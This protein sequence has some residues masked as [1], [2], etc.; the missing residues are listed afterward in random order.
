MKRRKKRV[1]EKGNLKISI[2][3]R[4]HR[5]DRLP[6][7]MDVAA[8]IVMEFMGLVSLTVASL[9]FRQH[10]KIRGKQ[11][12]FLD[13][14]NSQT[15]SERGTGKCFSS[16]WVMDNISHK[17]RKL[18]HATP[19]LM[20]SISLAVGVFAICVGTY[21][22]VNIISFGYALFVALIGAA[23]LLGTDAFEAYSYTNAIR[24]VALEQLDK[25]DQSYIELARDAMEKAFLRFSSMGVAFALLGPFIPQIFNV[26]VN[27]FMVYVMFFFQASE[28]LF[29]VS[30]GVGAVIVLILPGLLLFLPEVLGR[31]LIRKG[32]SLGRKM[33]RRR[34]EQ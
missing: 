8:I 33:Y 6:I 4:L 9:F 28:V 12:E 26:I 20:A 32:K 18:L 34:V 24:K 14:I 31:I 5:L 15:I 17:P 13:A 16:E 10:R 30:L 2:K 7:N 29:A 11:R 3:L 21:L 23:L 25:E 19:F 27:A 1:Y 22:I